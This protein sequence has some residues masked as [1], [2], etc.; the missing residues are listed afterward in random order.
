MYVFFILKCHMQ[1]KCSFS[2]NISAFTS[3]FPIVCL[4]IERYIL[5]LFL[6]GLLIFIKGT[7][8][9]GRERLEESWPQ[10]KLH[11]LAAGPRIVTNVYH[12]RRIDFL[13][14]YVFI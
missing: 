9:I 11:Y 2:F 7:K 5:V 6:I 1:G 3:T 13:F 10:T 8:R 14:Y 4:D 12:S